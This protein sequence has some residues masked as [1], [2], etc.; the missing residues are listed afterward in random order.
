M[1]ITHHLDDATLMSFAAG[2]LPAALSAVAA[3]HVAMCARCRHEIAKLG[4]HD[5]RSARIR[6]KHKRTVRSMSEPRGARPANGRAVDTA[7]CRTAVQW[8]GDESAS[9]YPTS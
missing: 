3:A 6:R 9:D 2:S 5:T 1:T 4:R 7:R 8:S